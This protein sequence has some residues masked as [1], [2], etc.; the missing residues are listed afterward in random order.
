ML[1]ERWSGVADF[2]I[3]VDEPSD[4][5]DWSYEAHDTKLARHARARYLLQLAVYSLGIESVQGTMPRR[6]HVILGTDETET[7]ATADFMAYFRRL[8]ERFLEVA[9]ADEYPTYPDRVRHCDICDWKARCDAQRERD[10]YLGLVAGV[11]RDQIPKLAAAGAGTLTALGRSTD[12]LAPKRMRPETV[13]RLR[14]QA[15]LQLHERET[16]DPVLELRPPGDGA[17]LSR[18]PLPS[19]GD[20]FF[21][22]E[23]DP[24]VGEGLEYLFGL[25]YLEDG[26]WVYRAFWGHDPDEERRAFEA[27]VDLLTERVKRFPDAHVYHYA[28]YEVTALKRLMGRYGT[29]EDA[30]DDL[31]RHQTFVDLYRV[32]YES[33]RHSLPG[34]GLKKVETWF[35]EEREAEVTDAGGSIVA[36]E[37]WLR[38]RDD[39]ELEAIERYNEEDCRS[40]RALRDWLLGL[41]DRAASEYRVELGW[42]QQPNV[43][44]SPDR[45]QADAELA[46]LSERLRANRG[47]PGALLAELL[48]VPPPRGE[49]GVVGVLRPAGEDDRGADR[50]SRGAVRSCASRRRAGGGRPL[51][52]STRCASR[53][54]TTT[55]RPADVVDPSTE[56]DEEIVSI[57]E[58]GDDR[59][60][61]VRIKRGPGAA[62]EAAAAR[63]R[64]RA[65][66]T[67][68]ASS[69]PLCGVSRHRWWPA[70]VALPR[71]RDI[72]GQDVAAREW[73][74]ARSAA[75]A[76]A[77]RG[78][79]AVGSRR[80]ARP[81][82]A[83][84][85][86]PAGL[87]QDLGR[88]ADRRPPDAAGPAGRRDGAQ[89]QGDPQPAGRDRAPAPGSRASSSAASR[90]RRR[91]TRSRST[92]AISSSR[93]RATAPSR[94][95][96]TCCWSPARRGCSRARAWRRRS[97]TLLIDEAGQLSLA[98]ALAVATSG[99]N[100]VLLGDPQ[101]LAQVSQGTHPGGSGVLGAAAPARRRRDDA[102]RAGH[103]PRPQLPHAPRR[104]R[105][106]LRDRVRGPARAGAGAARS[107]ASMRAAT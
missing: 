78:G 60:G 52:S 28:A 81:V 105:V 59:W 30:V 100:V 97:T 54:R 43:K 76:R 3:R 40:T 48:A 56:E 86:G 99:R 32:V 51:A 58:A 42:H 7:V 104:V 38:S 36:Y 96:T 89:P 44:P 24:F 29:R 12:E 35:G 41:R 11:R 67:G 92:T 14:N 64:P 10:D 102:A 66:R 27:T 65:A 73:D 31:L 39:S 71:A 107:S 23:G 45:A 101:Q 49:A 70:T 37:H 33:I 83:R 6:A 103:L 87:G 4:L 19:E 75:P 69:R 93:T 79:R 84:R 13:T 80:A 15:R 1:G 72:L 34:Y 68:P 88:C 18:L 53:R 90:S 98:D 16:G 9:E 74:R 63:A 94:R 57:E 2:L 77:R 106:H 8:R 91:A 17:G 47:E 25:V 85:P 62:D 20:V 82:R 22:M 21:D 61:S 46:V 55:S 26:E 50:R 5:G 95:P